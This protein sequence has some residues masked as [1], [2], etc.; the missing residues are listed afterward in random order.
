MES[1]KISIELKILR[2]HDLYLIIF[3]FFSHPSRI[4]AVNYLS[5]NETS[6]MYRNS[7]SRIAAQF[8]TRNPAER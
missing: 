3:A 8:E 4:K 2:L 7:V 6:A 1:L 5:S